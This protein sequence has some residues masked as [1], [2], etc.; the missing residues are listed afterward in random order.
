MPNGDK[1]KKRELVREDEKT[2]GYRRREQELEEVE[3]AAGSANVQTRGLVQQRERALER[4]E[5]VIRLRR[6]RRPTP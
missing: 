3:D 2:A 5:H 6:K 1:R 4:Q